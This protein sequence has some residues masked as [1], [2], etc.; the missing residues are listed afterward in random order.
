MFRKIILFLTPLLILTILFLVLVLFLNRESGK[1][2]LQVTS[3]P[4]SQ[5]F[6]DGK[7]VGKT[8]LC[9]CDLPQLLKVGDYSIRLVPTQSGFKEWEQ[10][11][12]IY[13]GALTVV[14]RTFDK[15]VSS[16]TGSIITLSDIGDKNKSELLV[17]SFPSG[18]EVV[19]D[20][21][22]KGTT[23]ILIKDITASDHEIKILKDGYSEKVVKVKTIPGK[24]LQVSTDLG[25]RTDLTDQ[26][27]TASATLSVTPSPSA[28]QKVVILDTPTGF[29]RVRTT[30]SVSSAQI[31]TVNPGDKLDLV[32][33]QDG[34]F[35]ISLP[36]GK[37]GWISS[38]YAKKE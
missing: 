28:G 27:A 3:K 36:D 26:D 21:N 33:E 34:W 7:F 31:G 11:I 20:S 38:D 5:V 19:V 32:S 16:A 29:L 15:N 37:S 24:R 12:T 17:I 22:N 23:P 4:D 13:Q 14:D 35:E 18:A 2:A 1:G 25:I 6:L 10:K 9:L 8:P 30:A